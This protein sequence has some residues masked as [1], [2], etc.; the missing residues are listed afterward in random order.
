MSSIRTNPIFHPAG[1]SRLKRIIS[2]RVK[3]AWP[4]V[5]ETAAGASPASSTTNGSRIQS[6]AVLVPTTATMAPPITNPTVVPTTARARFWPVPR[7]LDRRTLRVANATQKACWTVRRSATSTASPRPAAPRRLLCSH[8]EL[9]SACEPARSWAAVRNPTKPSGW[10]PSTFSSQVRRSARAAK[11]TLAAICR[12][13]KLSSCERKLG[14]SALTTRRAFSSSSTAAVDSGSAAVLVRSSS[15]RAALS[16]A[17]AALSAWPVCPGD[18]RRS[19]AASSAVAAACLT[20]HTA[21]IG[22]G[23]AGAVSTLRRTIA[24]SHRSSSTRR[25]AARADVLSPVGRYGVAKKPVWTA[26]TAASAAAT[27]AW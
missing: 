11:S 10:R 4:A 6:T 8:R 16:W 26:S 5:K 27:E 3:A 2:V 25:T 9:R 13:M 19:A 22:F 15:S 24:L 21:S 18:S 7:A 12:T 20:A 23:P 1:A 14:S 17:V